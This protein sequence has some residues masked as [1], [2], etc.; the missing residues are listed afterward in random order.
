MLSNVT[1]IKKIKNRSF[2]FLRTR[3]DDIGG[4]H[5]YITYYAIL[6]LLFNSRS[7]LLL[8]LLYLYIYIAVCHYSPIREYNISGFVCE[9]KKHS[10]THHT[11]PPHTEFQR[12]PG[13]LAASAALLVTPLIRLPMTYNNSFIIIIYI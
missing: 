3:E 8:L 10:L 6:L 5:L 9:K 7:T 13:G 1:Q 11:C 4:T 12:G 2:F